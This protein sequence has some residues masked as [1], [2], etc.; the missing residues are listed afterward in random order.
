LLNAIEWHAEIG[1]DAERI[2]HLG[3]AFA[4]SLGIDPESTGIAHEVAPLSRSC[5]VTDNLVDV[6]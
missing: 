6:I 4:R 5:P 1:R 3:L 2:H